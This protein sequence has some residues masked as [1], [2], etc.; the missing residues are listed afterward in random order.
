[1][2]MM[3]N[4]TQTA[5]TLALI[6]CL[7]AP[8]MA[9]DFLKEL[10]NEVAQN[11]IPEASVVLE[12]ILSAIEEVESENAYEPLSRESGAPPTSSMSE[13]EAYLSLTP[14]RKMP[15]GVER[16]TSID[17]VPEHLCPSD[18]ADPTVSQSWTS[19]ADPIRQTARLYSVLQNR[20]VLRT[21]DCSCTGHSMPWA[22]GE[23]LFKKVSPINPD[24]F[25][26]IIIKLEV[27]FGQ[28][29][30]QFCGAR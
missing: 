30:K 28:T 9:E 14:T 25:E 20:N 23:D 10:R 29:V 2:I 11:F 13:E 8:V 7:P 5:A 16:D 24:K 15:Q 6:A 19:L 3:K 12:N 17:Y 22:M 26:G 1:M 21:G 4:L 18:P 27:A